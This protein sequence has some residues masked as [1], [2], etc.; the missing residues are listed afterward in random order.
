MASLTGQ[1]I[2]NTYHGLLKTVGNQVNIGADS[3]AVNICDG[4]ETTSALWLS[5]KRV[6]INGGT[7]GAALHINTSDSAYVTSQA[8]LRIEAVSSTTARAHG[9][10]VKGGAG[11]ASGAVIKA[12]DNSDAQIL[13]V[14]G[15]GKVAIGTHTANQQLHTYKATG[16]VWNVVETGHTGSSGGIMLTGG[17]ADEARIYMGDAG[18]DDAGRL[19]YAN[20]THTMSL[21]TNNTQKMIIKDDGNVGIGTGVY[22]P[23]E[24][25]TIYKEDAAAKMRIQKREVDG[26]QVADQVVGAVEFW[27]NDDTYNPGSGAGEQALRA[28]VQAIIADTS[29]GTALQFFSG[30]PN[31]A[32]VERMR[33]KADGNIEVVNSFIGTNANQFDIY[34]NTTDASDNKRL[35]IGGGGDVATSRGAFATFNGNEHSSNPGDLYL[36]AGSTG[37]VI[38]DSGKVGIGIAAPLALLHLYESTASTTAATDMLTIDA[39]SDGTSAVG[40]GSSIAFRGE[41]HEGTLQNMAKV[42]A[43]TEVNSGSTMSSALIFQT[44]IGGVLGERVRIDNTGKVGIGTENPTKDLHISTAAGAIIN[45]HREDGTIETDEVLGELW[46]SGKD[47]AAGSHVGAKIVAH[48]AA[49]NWDTNSDP[50]KASTKL[51]FYTQDNGT[52][53]TTDSLA[54]ARMLI[55]ENGKVGIGEASPDNLLHITNA[56]STGTA[57]L[58]LE[59]LDTDEPFIRFQGTTASD[60]TKSLSTAGSVGSLTGHI[61]VSIN[62]T[63]FWIPYYATS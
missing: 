13:N 5:N 59:Q 21:W 24:Q 29:S 50:Q 34:M 63:D 55:D 11:S 36:S 30:P 62:G 39:Y 18:D 20:D 60:Q 22:T 44:A 9:L 45:L 52:D 54:E 17:S 3:A 4:E 28:S 43:V 57:N 37:D 40:F 10:S 53:D 35:R 38:V 2:G 15:D 26:A 32:A 51:S 42:S 47:S 7:P 16:N 1:Q 46:F 19:V 27:T 61:R 49:T 56:A 6:G 12:I 14:Q 23:G 8:A 33:I 48:C 58:K 31:G 41:R 25:L